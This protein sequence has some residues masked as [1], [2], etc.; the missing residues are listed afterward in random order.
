MSGVV[1]SSGHAQRHSPR[2]MCFAL[3]TASVSSLLPKPMHSKSKWD[4]DLSDEDEVNE[5]RARLAPAGLVFFVACSLPV[6]PLPSVS[7]CRSQIAPR[8]I[9]YAAMGRVGAPP[10]EPCANW[11]R[12]PTAIHSNPVVI[13]TG[14]RL[15][16]SA[17]SY[18]VAPCPD[19]FTNARLL[20]SLQIP[21][22]QTARCRCGRWQ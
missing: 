18:Y 21:N 15:S 20:A 7:P 12:F 14:P 2:R 4:E 6:L 9:W 11:H 1:L 22:Q 8:M 16:G 5:V 17:L 10:L 3:D 13:P 19:P